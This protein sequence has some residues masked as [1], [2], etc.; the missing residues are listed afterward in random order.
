MAARKETPV[1]VDFV[2]FEGVPFSPPPNGRSLTLPADDLWPQRGPQQSS[3]GEIPPQM[4]LSDIAMG[5]LQ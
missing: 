3:W 2:T 1:R 4:L 5:R